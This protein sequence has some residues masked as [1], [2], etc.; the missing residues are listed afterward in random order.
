MELSITR[1]TLNKKLPYAEMVRA[2][3]RAGFRYVELSAAKWRAAL[4]EDPA[5]A[6]L[7]GP[8]GIQPWHAGWNLR[9][10]WDTAR[11]AQAMAAAPAA[12]DLT[13][14]LGSR[15]GTLVLPHYENGGAPIP[16]LAETQ[17]HIGTVADLAAERGLTVC[18]EYMGLRPQDPPEYGVRTLPRT[19]EVLRQVG[20]SNVG[21]LIDSYHWHISGTPDLGQI[22]AGTPMWVHL[23]DA[24][25]GMPVHLLRDCHRVLP[26]EG[27]IDLV[28]L[29]TALHARGYDGPLSVEVKHPELHALPGEQAAK[30]AFEAGYAVLRRAD[31]ARS[32]AEGRQR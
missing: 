14:S 3:H 29:L 9:L 13:A 7:I 24:P 25:A 11:F 28:G 19:L 12:M 16:G 30:R 23:N 2:A 15:S 4:E 10:N 1:S 17:D 6:K 8:H 32:G 27:V 22:P 20:R 26:G 21:V 31:L 5:L 18:V